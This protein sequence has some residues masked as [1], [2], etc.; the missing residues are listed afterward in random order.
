MKYLIPLAFSFFFLA[1]TPSYGTP[2]M[3]L[4]PFASKQDC[5]QAR[6]W[7][8]EELGRYGETSACFVQE[9]RD[10]GSSRK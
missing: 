4:G 3:K 10:A 2:I 5:E 8:N 9:D 6:K 7:T 1:Y